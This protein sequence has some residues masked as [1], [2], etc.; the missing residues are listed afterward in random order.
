MPILNKGETFVDGQQ[1]SGQRLNDLIDNATALPELIT[2]QTPIADPVAD[3]DG[4]LIHDASAAA[5]RKVTV[6]E[7]FAGDVALNSSVVTTSVVNGQTGADIA[8]N[9]NNGTTV[10]GSAFTSVDGITVTVNSVAHGLVAGQFILVAASDAAYSGTF[11][12][13]S[14]TANSFTYLT[15]SEQTPASGTCTYTKQGAVDVNGNLLVSDNVIVGQDVGIAGSVQIDGALN[16][17]GAINSSGSATFSGF[18]D[19]TGSLKVNNQTAYLL[20]GIVEVNIPYWNATYAGAY[21]TIYASPTF[22]KPTEEI[23]ILELMVSSMGTG[24]DFEYAVRL[25]SQTYLTGQYL[26][27]HHYQDSGGGGNFFRNTE[28]HRYLF[29]AGVVFTNETLKIDAWAGNGSSM[30]MFATTVTVGT[31]FTQATQKASVFRIYKYKTAVVPV[32]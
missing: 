8:I 32:P 7:L 10:A 29:P 11:L 26:S 15:L 23:W 12:I 4:L 5:L 21:D 16:A 24:Y 13:A 2:T 30:R 6:Q 17:N 25:G 22:T 3:G 28:T 31:A 1:V 19:F 18:A 27:F 14:Y 20:T 9:P